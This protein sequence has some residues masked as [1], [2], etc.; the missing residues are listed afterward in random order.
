[1]LDVAAILLGSVTEIAPNFA[2]GH[3]NLGVV[4]MAQGALDEAIAG[5][6]Q[7]IA[8]QP[9][10]ANAHYNLGNALKEQ[11][12]MDEAIASYRKA[13]VLTPNYA[14]LHSNLGDAL[15]AQGRLDEAIA[16]YRTA[17]RLDS[18][19][20]ELHYNLGDALREREDLDEA[21]ASYRREIEL[22]PDYA[23]AYNNLGNVLKDQ[24]KQDE[25]AEAYQQAIP[26]KPDFAE[27]YSNLGE[28]FYALGRLDEA[29]ASNRR[30]LEIRPD[31]AETY[32]SLGNALRERGRLD[33]AAAC[34]RQALLLKPDF[35]EAYNGLGNT[36][37]A[38]GRLDEAIACYRQVLSLKPDST[39]AYSNL[40]YTMQYMDTLTPAEVFSEHQR[41]A[42]RFETPLKAHWRAHANSRDPG[43]RLRI[44]YVS[45]DF[46]N[47]AVAFFIDPILAGHDKSQVEIYCYYNHI[48][49]DAHTEQIAA[50]ADHWLACSKMSD[51]QLA[52]RIRADGIDILVGLSGHTGY[53]SLPV[54]ARTPAPVQ[55]TWIGY[56][57]ST[58]LT[59]M[60]YR[61]TNAE[62]D[63]PGLTERYH[64]ESLVR[65]PDSGVAYRPA[66]GCPSV[67]PLPALSA[68][69][70]VF[71]SLNNLIKI[72]PSVVH[73]WARILNA[74][75]HARLML[76]NITDAG[77]RQR[78]IERF[79]QAG[80]DA[81]RLILP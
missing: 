69:T 43:R 77:I 1:M 56:A 31:S 50:H 66:P 36:L 34:G 21:A 16:S 7:A 29:I 63:P 9:N 19:L 39:I 52:E 32:N 78:V 6:R 68:D 27:A 73:L 28:A 42:E 71:A 74:L 72:N 53:T 24:D 25:A 67:N 33:E 60:D 2:D 18:N 45:A 20:V 35:A 37:Q 22:K 55:A 26:I 12:R 75:P 49:R 10:H 8:L 11:S 48:K 23:D 46:Y 41:Y 38:Q 40:L 81:D 54:F 62:M 13:L 76:G 4:L 17:L 30:A 64:S 47:H 15:Q 59:A 70:F 14:Q 5:Y 79:G 3:N 57:G 44:G 58:G 65:M 80:V 61:I 51:E